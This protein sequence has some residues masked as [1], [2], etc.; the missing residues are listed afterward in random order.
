ML[1]GFTGAEACSSERGDAPQREQR[2][3]SPRQEHG[4]LRRSPLICEL[5]AA[6]CVDVSARRHRLGVVQ[7]RSADAERLAAK[8]Y[9]NNARSVGASCGAAAALIRACF[10]RTRVAA[11]ARR[12]ERAARAGVARAVLDAARA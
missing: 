4:L 9:K 3:T 1:A 8:G 10:A 5:S 11:R 6:T 7:T 12:L 2:P